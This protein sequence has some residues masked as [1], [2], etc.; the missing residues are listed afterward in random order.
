MGVEVDP[1]SYDVEVV[2]PF[3]GISTWIVNELVLR[4]VLRV[5]VMPECEEVGR[6]RANCCD[7]LEA[8]LKEAFEPGNEI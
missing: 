4:F 3:I 2:H 1:K 7:S 6:L 8:H 5:F